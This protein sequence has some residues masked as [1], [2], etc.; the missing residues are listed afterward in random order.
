MLIEVLNSSLQLGLCS[1]DEHFL[2]YSHSDLDFYLYI[3]WGIPVVAPWLYDSKL[4]P[5]FIKFIYLFFVTHT[6]L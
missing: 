4:Y 3:F 6:Y 5:P 2:I 1:L